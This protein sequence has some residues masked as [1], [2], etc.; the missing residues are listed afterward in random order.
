MKIST[1]FFFFLFFSFFFFCESSDQLRW[2]ENCSESLIDRSRYWTTNSKSNTSKIFSM[3]HLVEWEVVLMVP[4]TYTVR[5]KKKSRLVRFFIGGGYWEQI[6]SAQDFWDSGLKHWKLTMNSMPVFWSFFSQ[7]SWWRKEQP[8]TVDAAARPRH[9]SGL[10]AYARTS[11]CQCT[12]S[13]TR[14]ARYNSRKWWKI[15]AAPATWS[16]L[17][18]RGSVYDFK[19]QPN[20][21][22]RYWFRD[23]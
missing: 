18:D 6:P 15:G 14:Y 5:K 10:Y 3:I 20:T 8:A 11:T 4:L 7:V 21:N 22:S 23:T 17:S 16:R 2:S 19:T 12:A 1:T 9:S 13:C